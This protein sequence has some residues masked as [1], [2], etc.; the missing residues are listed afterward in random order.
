MTKKEKMKEVSPKKVNTTP[1][2]AF[3]LK[4][5]E[6]LEKRFTLSSKKISQPKAARPSSG[7]GI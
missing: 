3:T 6:E 5:A 7:K 4:L 1:N 2:E